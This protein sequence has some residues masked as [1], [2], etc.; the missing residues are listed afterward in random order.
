[1]LFTLLFE[2]RAITMAGLSVDIVVKPMTT[3][4]T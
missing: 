3:T 1:M 4:V 2:G